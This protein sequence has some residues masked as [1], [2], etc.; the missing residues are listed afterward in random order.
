MET[1]ATQA[2]KG[3]MNKNSNV[4]DKMKDAASIIKALKSEDPIALAKRMADKNPEFAEFVEKNK[5][6]SADEIGKEYGVDL[7]LFNLI[8]NNVRR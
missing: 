5:G 7:S 3:T 2:V 1:I 6:K 4:I 8:Y